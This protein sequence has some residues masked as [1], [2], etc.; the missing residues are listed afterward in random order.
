MMLRFL[1]DEEL[2]ERNPMK[3]IKNVNEPPKEIAVLTVEELRH[4][5]DTPNKQSYSDF[6]VHVI[7]NLL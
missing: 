1:V 7:M 5:L 2:I 3:Q 4:L 6:Q